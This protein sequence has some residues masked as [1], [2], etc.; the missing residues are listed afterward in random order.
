MI[1]EQ[2]IL[3]GFYNASAPQDWESEI[4]PVEKELQFLDRNL[5]I[6]WNP[7]AFITRPGTYD[8]MG[9]A[10]P[11]TYEERYQVVVKGKTDGL[12]TIVWTVVEGDGVEK[13]YKPIGPWLVEFMR[14]WDAENVHRMTAMKKVLDDQYAVAQAIEN[15]TNERRKE[16]TTKYVTDVLGIKPIMSVVPANLTH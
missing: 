15:D 10:I 2:Q 13:R 6:I 1:T 4:K 14:K 11:P 8:A 16:N 7:Q 5:R 12:L 3:E 9:T